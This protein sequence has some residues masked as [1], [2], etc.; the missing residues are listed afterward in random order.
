[1]I[2]SGRSTVDRQWQGRLAEGFTIERFQIDWDRRQV[3]CPQGRFGAA[4]AGL[5]R[6]HPVGA[7]VSMSRLLQRIACPARSVLAAHA[8]R[9]AVAH[10]P[11][12]SKH[13]REHEL[14]RVA[15]SRQ[16]TEDFAALYAQR[17]GIEGAI[18]QGVRAFGLR[19]ARYRGL[20]KT[21]LQDVATATAMNLSRLHH[22]FEG[23]LPTTT[24][25]SRFA[26]LAVA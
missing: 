23:D 26:R 18:S 10:A 19:Q 22:W 16:Q 9:R 3:T 8:P 21:H 11:S 5:R 7:P 6:R 15:R 2:S 14:L 24:R 17:A 1:M 20:R 4:S 12:P 13:A 25:R